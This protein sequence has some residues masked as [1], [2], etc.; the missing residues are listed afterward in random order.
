MA[1]PYEITLLRCNCHMRSPGSQVL[2]VF[3]RFLAQYN[4]NPYVSEGAPSDAMRARADNEW[5]LEQPTASLADQYGANIVSVETI[6]IVV[7]WTTQ[8][9]LRA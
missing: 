6:Y 1:N 9:S 2:Y 3:L 8:D 7:F 4:I 5:A